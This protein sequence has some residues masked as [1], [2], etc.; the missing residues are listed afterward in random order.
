L[1]AIEVGV[2][3]YEENYVSCLVGRE[4]LLSV[5]PSSMYDYSKAL[6]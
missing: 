2:D 1:I 6:E 5:I 3:G 4:E